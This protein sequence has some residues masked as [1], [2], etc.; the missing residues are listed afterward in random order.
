MV[1]YM[2]KTKLAGI[3]T[4]VSLLVTCTGCG[5]TNYTSDSMVDSGDKSSST[6]SS[7]VSDYSSN[8]Y[9]TMEYDEEISYDYDSGSTSTNNSYSDSGETLT[10]S[11]ALD[12]DSANNRKMITTVNMSVETENFTDLVNTVENKVKELN[13]YMESYETGYQYGYCYN[14]DENMQY[15]RLTVRIPAD[16]MDGFITTVEDNANIISR[17][18][19]TEDVTLSYVDTESRKKA[20]ETEY[21]SLLELLAKAENVDS[22][23]ALQTRLSDVRYEIESLES[24][25]RTY[26][27]KVNYSTIYLYIDEVSHITPVITKEKTTWDKIGTGLSEN[28]Y[29]IGQWFVNSFITFIV[30]LPYI[31][32]LAIF[33]LLIFIIIKLILRHDKKKRTEREKAWQQTITRQDSQH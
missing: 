4:L 16:N 20:L 28:L 14:S 31:G 8:D 9:A 5:S 30:I 29:A 22:I 13:G 15:A 6:S 25:L 17:S 26:D 24:Q 1:N 3:I 19:S 7:Y 27:N 32:I 10:D 21:D 11:A 23:I 33:G 12:Y 2:K 18:E